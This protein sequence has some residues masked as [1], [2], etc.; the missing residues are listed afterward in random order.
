M[1][2]D[3]LTR[4]A[5]ATTSLGD[6]DLDHGCCEAHLDLAWCGMDTDGSPLIAGCLEDSDNPCVVCMEIDACSVCGRDLGVGEQ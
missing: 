4:P 1:T 6:S 3:T 2:A 5:E